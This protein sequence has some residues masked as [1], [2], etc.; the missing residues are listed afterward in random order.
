MTETTIEPLGD[1]VLVLPIAEE[2]VTKSGIILPDQAR[3]KPHRGKIIAL[4]PLVNKG[5]EFELKAVPGQHTHIIRAFDPLAIGDEVLYS[6]YGGTEL[7]VDL[8]EVVLL[9]E[10]DIFCRIKEAAAEQVPGQT[11]LYEALDEAAVAS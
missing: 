4:G 10:S 1:R 7:K 8:R 3:E 2:T 11:D 6:K 9:R 5:Q